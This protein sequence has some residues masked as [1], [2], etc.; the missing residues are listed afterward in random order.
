VE[1]PSKGTI[2]FR[3]IHSL[4]QTAKE[5]T[6]LLFTCILSGI[7]N[8]FTLAVLQLCGGTSK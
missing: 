3:F 5:A 4:T 1:H 2:W 8:L 7:S 6:E